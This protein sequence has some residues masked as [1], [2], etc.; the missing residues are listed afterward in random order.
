MDDQVAQP[1]RA[2]D[3]ERRAEFGQRAALVA[4]EMP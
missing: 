1:E 2:S 4:R 3:A